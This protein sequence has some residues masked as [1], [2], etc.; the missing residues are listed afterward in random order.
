MAAKLEPT[1]GR[2]EAKRLPFAFAKR[3]GV[4][5]QKQLDGCTEVIYREGAAAA[6]LAEVRRFLGGPVKF[7]KVDRE[8]FDARLQLSYESG[9]AM[10]VM[11]GLDEETDLLEV[12]QALPG[13]LGPARE[14][15]R[16]TDHP[17][18][19]RRANRGGQEERLGHSRGNRMRTAW[20][21]DSGLT[22]SCKK[23]CS[24]AAR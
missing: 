2:T 24:R 13:A 11:E 20:Q 1:L 15:R 4:L 9:A 12:A 5:I 22:V 14:R 18:D 21:C 17:L 19:Q 23:S 16:G 6:S 10:T 7:S 8:A 3:H